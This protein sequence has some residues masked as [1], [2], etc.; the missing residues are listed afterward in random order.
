MSTTATP[1]GLVPVNLIGGRPYSGAVTHYPILS[2]DSVAIFAGDIV[3]LTVGTGNVARMTHDDAMPN[4]VGV[5]MGCAY[6]DATYGFTHR[7]YWP[8][9]QVATD[10]VAY[11]C[12]DPDV[13]YECQ[14][15]G[16]IAREAVGENFGLIEALA[17]QTTTGNSRVQIPNGTG[18]TTA[19]LPVVL[20][21]FPDRIGSTVGD[22]FTD[23]LVRLNTHRHRT[24]AGIT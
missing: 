23:C 6:T 16:A 8:A 11:V 14:A 9:N 19:T 20:M 24:L 10:A 12:D 21:G 1:R 2:G 7:Q 22:A 17:G 15:D 4:M 5:F 18:A 13:I 3:E